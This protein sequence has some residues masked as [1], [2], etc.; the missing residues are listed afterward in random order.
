VANGWAIVPGFESLPAASTVTQ[1][2][3]GVEV[4]S[5]DA[6]DATWTIDDY[7]LVAN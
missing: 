6:K 2:S 4:C 5:T 3:F 7:S 1:L